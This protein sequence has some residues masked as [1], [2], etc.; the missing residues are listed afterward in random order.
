MRKIFVGWDSRE[1][2]AYEVCKYSIQKHSPTAMVNPLKQDLMRE[3]GLYWRPIDTKASTEFTFTRF[4]TPMMAGFKDWVLFCDSDF[5]FTTDVEELFAQAD[6]RYAIM[7]VKHDYTPKNT[8]K[9]DGKVQLQYPR[10]N[11]SSCMLFNAGHEKNKILT[12]DLLNHQT[13]LYLH[14]MQ[15]LDDDLIGE[16]SCEWNWLAGWYEEPE[17]GKPKAIH[18]TEGGP[19]FEDYRDCEYADVWNQYHK[20]YNGFTNGKH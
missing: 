13:A 10:K 15:W 20:E 5:V 17:D 6:D 8:R 11:W 18:Y 9:M 3:L 1:P 19:W 14:R 7:C 4:F 16:L 2:I 12:P